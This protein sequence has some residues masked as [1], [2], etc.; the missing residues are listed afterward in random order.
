MHI[1]QCWCP[2]RCHNHVGRKK[3]FTTKSESQ[4]VNICAFN[5]WF[6]MPWS[7]GVAV[8]T[9]DSAFILSH[10]LEWRSIIN[11]RLP[12]LTNR[13]TISWSRAWSV[14]S[15]H[16]RGGLERIK[17][18]MMSIMG[19]SFVLS[20]FQGHETPSHSIDSKSGLMEKVLSVSLCAGKEKRKR[21][22]TPLATLVA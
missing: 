8:V 22:M 18:M 9:F 19:K 17:A 4:L 11:D 7:F 10:L 5:V 3:G 15:S 14:A 13:R 12:S 1:D 2:G 16:G 6:I 21:G 20:Q